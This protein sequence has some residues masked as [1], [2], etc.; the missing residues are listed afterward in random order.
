MVRLLTNSPFSR[1]VVLALGMV[2]LA[3]GCRGNKS[4]DPPVHLQQNMDF[5]QSYEAQEVNEW[6]PDKRAMR[7]PVEGT[8]ARS[9]GGAPTDGFLRTDDHLYEGRG[10]NGRLVDSLPAGMKLTKAFL[11]RGQNLSLI[12]I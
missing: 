8:Q 1:S 6:F 3:A 2:V 12:H 7:P 9:L 4:A 11:E 5:A 10:A